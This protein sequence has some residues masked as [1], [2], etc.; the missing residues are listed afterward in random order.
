MLSCTCRGSVEPVD[1]AQLTIE[2]TA[3]VGWWRL[4]GGGCVGARGITTINNLARRWITRGTPDL[5]GEQSGSW[6]DAG[7]LPV[8]RAVLHIGV[9]PYIYGTQILL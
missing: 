2:A 9:E 8:G 1:P 6:F 5:G 4:K 7:L 3:L